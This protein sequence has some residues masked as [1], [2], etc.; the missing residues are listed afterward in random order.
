MDRFY[1]LLAHGYLPKEL[2]PIFSSVAFAK[3]IHT[4]GYS[5]R[6]EAKKWQRSCS[7][8]LQ[9]KPHYKR[10]LDIIAPHAIFKQAHIIASNYKQLSR[11]FTNINGNC[12]CPAFNRKT[13]FRRAVRPYAIGI[14]YANRK[15]DLRARFPM[16]L[17]LDIKNYYRSVYTHSI[18]WAI[19][20]KKYAKAN[21][22]AEI[23]GNKIDK[24]IREGQDGQTIGIPTGPDTSFIVSEVIMCRIVDALIKKRSIK[25]DR[26]VRYY[27]DFEYGCET[28]DEAHRVLCAFEDV[29][30]EYEL[31]TNSDK[32]K[33]ISGPKQIESPWLFKLR[34]LEWSKGIKTDYIIE[35]FAAISEI[36][37][38]YPNDHVYR[39]FLSRMKTCIVK[40]A[41]WS[42]YEKIL[43]TI[44]QENQGNAKEVFDQLVAYRHIGYPINKRLLKEVL[45]RK[46]LIQLRM[47]VTSELSWF[48]YGYMLFDLTFSND[49][50]R[51]VFERGDVPSRILAVKLAQTH[52]LSFKAEVTACVRDWDGDV[53]N[54]PEW[55]LAY[56]TMAHNWQRRGVSVPLHAETKELYEVLID[57]QVSFLD[58]TIITRVEIP[59][60][61]KSKKVSKQ[62]EEGVI[63]PDNPDI[64]KCLLDEEDD[65]SLDDEV[66]EASDSDE[67]E[68]LDND[69]E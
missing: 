37:E 49:M 42:A 3:A 45:D 6:L 57:K 15:L 64:M 2:P 25:A 21:F 14:G 9:Q 50:V 62:K 28:E 67:D 30:R 39:Y 23:L 12:S 51:R 46:I 1:R 55:L 7:Y 43:L 17:K 22:R 56:E 18:P 29:L 65:D 47:G 4:E 34:Q 11:A 10:R 16:I 38:Q 19:H 48:L 40:D 53:L 54:S 13:K 20:G 60:A 41:A 26:F 35:M 59:S 63:E 32:V 8:L 44:L 24:A 69:E 58:E 31:E 5:K 61:F 52:G 27:D 68:E 66:A 36:A 33:I